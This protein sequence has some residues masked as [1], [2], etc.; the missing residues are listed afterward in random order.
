M[1][2]LKIFLRIIAGC[3]IAAFATLAAFAAQAEDGIFVIYF[4]LLVINL[5]LLIL[6][7]FF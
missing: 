1:R 2:E 6:D 5:F 7:E 3:N 4:L